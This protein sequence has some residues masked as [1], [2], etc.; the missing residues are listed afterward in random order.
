MAAAAPQDFNGFLGKI[1]TLGTV[2]TD[3]NSFIAAMAYALTEAGQLKSWSN[4]AN[5]VQLG[6]LTTRIRSA[7]ID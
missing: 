3:G 6:M 5:A 1:A 7:Q 2:N 4:P